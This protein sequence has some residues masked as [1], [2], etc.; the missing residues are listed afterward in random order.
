VR[1]IDRVGNRGTWP[2]GPQAH[3]T[4]HLPNT[5]H[6]SIAAFF[7]DENRNDLWDEPTSVTNEITLMAVDLRFLNEAGQGV[8]SPT[9]GSSWEFTAT[10]HSGQTYR[11]WASSAD[12]RRVVSFTWPGGGEVY[13]V[14][15]PALG[16]WPLTRTYLPSVLR[17]G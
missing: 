9:V 14:T 17:H 11:L 7:A 3:T 10:I 2:E 16:L 1:A 5:L 12:H 15:H 8:V 13:T 6:L 4:L